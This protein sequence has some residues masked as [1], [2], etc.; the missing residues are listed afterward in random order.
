MTSNYKALTATIFLVAAGVFL[1]RFRARLTQAQTKSPK[2]AATEAWRARWV[3]IEHRA[4]AAEAGDPDSVRALAD[5]I[6]GQPHAFARVPPFIHSP[7][8]ERVIRAEMDY[9]SGEG[10]P[11]TDGD[12][13]RMIN[14]L[15]DKFALPDYARTS[16]HQILVMRF[17]ILAFTPEFM[18]KGLLKSEDG[19]P[20]NVGDSVNPTMSPLQACYLAMFAIDSKLVNPDYQMPPGEWEARRYQQSLNLWRDYQRAGPAER[21]ATSGGRQSGPKPR[22]VAVASKQT[23]LWRAAQ[24]SLRT[25]QPD[26]LIGLAQSALDNLGIEPMR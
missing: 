25:I 19:T 18:G 16:E 4:K 20:M 10:G 7:V 23:D 1:W 5:E 11:V 13:A 12:V 8:E 2:G 26:Q 6:F 24:A 9:R 17:H 15:A 21:R 14:W 22:L 3:A